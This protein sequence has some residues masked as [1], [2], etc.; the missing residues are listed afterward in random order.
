[1]TGRDD[2]NREKIT[3]LIKPIF[4]LNLYFYDQP[5]ISYLFSKQK[6]TRRYKKLAKIGW[7][8]RGK[9]RGI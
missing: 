2:I 9:M 3:L 4:G 6:S 7:E 5:T 8:I 1:M